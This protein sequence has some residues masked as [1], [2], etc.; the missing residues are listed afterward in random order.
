MPY[1]VCLTCVVVAYAAL[2]LL[3]LVWPLIALLYIWMMF[4][5]LF[6][7]CDSNPVFRSMGDFRRNEILAQLYAGSQKQYT[8][9]SR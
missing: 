7:R 9:P 6:S 2:G 4:V 5:A 8:R 3:H 1:F